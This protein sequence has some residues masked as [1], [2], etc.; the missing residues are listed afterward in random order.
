MHVPCPACGT[1]TRFK[2]PPSEDTSVLVDCPG[3]DGRFRV[4]IQ[5]PEVKG[6]P[7]SYRRA[8]DYARRN[9]IDVPTAYS[10]LEGL[11][12]LEEARGTSGFRG[13]GPA[14]ASSLSTAPASSMSTAPPWSPPSPQP[15]ARWSA[16]SSAA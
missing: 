2:G 13:R 8:R 11:L 14:P 16:P 1:I 5:V 15:A 9:D 4:A 7:E 10:V 6:D 12:T 3:C